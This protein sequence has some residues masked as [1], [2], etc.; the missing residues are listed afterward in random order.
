MGVDGGGGGCG[1][2]QVGLVDERSIADVVVAGRRS[3]GV[4]GLL[5]VVDL[6]YWV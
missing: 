1:S 3:V 5:G 4:T 6:G 2:V